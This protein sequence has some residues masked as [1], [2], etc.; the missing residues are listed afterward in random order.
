MITQI[1]N[2]ESIL[3]KQCSITNIMCDPK[4]Y[5]IAFISKFAPNKSIFSHIVDSHCLY[6]NSDIGYLEFI[7]ASIL[8]NDIVFL[9]SITGS[10]I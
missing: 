5:Y 9:D 2:V 7:S 1:K 8:E 10:I 6:F 3:L 4:D